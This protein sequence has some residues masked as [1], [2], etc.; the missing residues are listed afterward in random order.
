MDSSVSLKDEIWFLHVC[1]QVS[2]ELYQNHGTAALRLV[3]T[4]RFTNGVWCKVFTVKN[5]MEKHVDIFGIM[6]LKSIYENF[7]L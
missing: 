7:F 4:E 1:H 6:T 2:N 3:R 5:V